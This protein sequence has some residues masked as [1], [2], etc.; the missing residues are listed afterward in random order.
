MTTFEEIGYELDEMLRELEELERKVKEAEFQSEESQKH[1]TEMTV[2]EE[3]PTSSKLVEK[4]NKEFVK[5]E[6]KVDK[7]NEGTSSA[8]KTL[9]TKVVKRRNLS[10]IDRKMLRKR[11]SQRWMD[12]KSLDEFVR[13]RTA[14]EKE[15]KS[16]QVEQNNKK[17][18]GSDSE[19]RSAEV[20]SKDLDLI[21]LNQFLSEMEAAEIEKENQLKIDSEMENSNVQD[22]EAKETAVVESS[23]SS[24]GKETLDTEEDLVTFSQFI[25]D[26]VIR[27]GKGKINNQLKIRRATKGRSCKVEE[28]SSELR[29]KPTSEK[30]E[31]AKVN[32][33]A[34]EKKEKRKSRFFN[35]FSF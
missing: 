19:E 14:S 3:K 22:T 34:D 27:S 7:I 5:S 12:E 30:V 16:I 6:N 28:A 11:R 8:S 26:L 9:E 10:T 21:S 20:D 15:P 24:S 4:T 23:T 35:F 17:T 18:I 29:R 32:K 31:A 2:L 13:V 33:Q 25:D 1:E